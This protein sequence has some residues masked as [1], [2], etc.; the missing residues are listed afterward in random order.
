[1]L[2]QGM[3]NASLT[4]AVSC[5]SIGDGYV[6]ETCLVLERLISV[7]SMLAGRRV[8]RGTMEKASSPVAASLLLASFQKTRAVASKLERPNA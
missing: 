7:R 5:Q 6:G 4:R 3:S 2:I 1:M 8:G